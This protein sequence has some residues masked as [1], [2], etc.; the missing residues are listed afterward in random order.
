MQK[1]IALAKQ[2]HQ[3]IKTFGSTC[4][5]GFESVPFIIYNDEFQIAV[6]AG[7]PD[8]YEQIEDNIW[9]AKGRD[10][11]L[12]GNTVTEYHGLGVAIW[13][14][15]TWSDEVDIAMAT[16]CIYHEMFHAH[17]YYHLNLGRSDGM[18][19]DYQHTAKSVALTIAEN[20]YLLDILV[21]NDKESVLLN[22]NKIAN[23]RAARQVE[24]GEKYIQYDQ[25]EETG[26]GTAVYAEIK[27]AM[28]ISGK[29]VTE[30][31]SEY[32]QVLQTIDKTLTN[33]RA[34]LYTVGLI[35]CLACDYLDLDLQSDM[36][37]SG[38]TVF[39]WLSEKLSLPQGMEK[40]EDLDFELAEDL[41][42][43][44]NKTKID[45]IN[46]F[47]AL[48]YIEVN[49]HLNGL[50]PMNIVVHEN[51]CLHKWGQVTIDG[52]TQQLQ[53]PYLTEF[54][55]GNVFVATRMWVLTEES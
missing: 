9:L 4:W 33:Y 1:H 47:R 31:A 2:I 39:A 24:L 48:P 38:K 3:N 44:F 41:L 53:Q 12:F 13:N 25:G 20:Q 19:L 45:K 29:S 11:Q 21:N 46:E 55:D 5:T 23:L 49:G 15:D 52:V 6:G 17:Q 10:E 8:K 26:E 22:L 30:V 28:A 50:D 51:L 32:L 36:A 27:M 54:A 18:I 34:R 40:T 37:Q 7:F 35:L 16:S 14:V 42:A 43:K